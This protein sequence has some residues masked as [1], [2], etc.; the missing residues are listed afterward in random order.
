MDRLGV[1][2]L[3]AYVP[4]RSEK[5]RRRSHIWEDTGM[6]DN[7]SCIH[8]TNIYG[9]RGNILEDES[10]PHSAPFHVSQKLWKFIAPIL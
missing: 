2:R 7:V 10:R 5:A 1:S 9:A 6:F 8:K 3:K 4:M